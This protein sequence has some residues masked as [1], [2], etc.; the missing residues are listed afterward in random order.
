M[1]LYSTDFRTLPYAFFWV[2]KF[3]AVLFIYIQIMMTVLC[4]SLRTLYKLSWRFFDIYLVLKN[5]NYRDALIH[6]EIYQGGGS[7]KRHDNL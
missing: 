7:K 3:F 4:F 1:L 2:L 6:F 5:T